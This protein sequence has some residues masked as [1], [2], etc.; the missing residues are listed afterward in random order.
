MD[1]LHN[2][3]TTFSWYKQGTLTEG[4]ASVHLTSYQNQLNSNK[5]FNQGTIIEGEGPVQLTCT[6]R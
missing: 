6:L 1:L 4:E 3:I 5:R 2:T